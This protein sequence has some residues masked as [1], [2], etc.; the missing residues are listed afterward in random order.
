MTRRR[1]PLL[2][3]ALALP[4]AGW[5]ALALGA[6]TPLKGLIEQRAGD[7]LGRKVIIGGPVR[8]WLTPSSVQLIARDVHVAN[9]GWASTPALLRAD[10]VEARLEI[11]DLLIGR[12]G[13][14]A[15]ALRDGALELERSA[16]GARVN[17]TPGRTG[18]LFDPA[19][20][21][22]LS[23]ERM[24]LRYRD[25]AAK[26]DA[27][28]ELDE[29]GQGVIRLAG[30]A[31]LDGQ[32]VG[33]EGTL[34]SAPSEPTRLDIGARL[35]GVSLRLARLA[36]RGFPAGRRARTSRNWPR[37]AGSSCRRCPI[38]RSARASAM[39]GKAGTSAISR[40]ASGGPTSPAG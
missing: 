20:V 36:R 35:S 9:A 11:F 18:A 30:A 14:R 5:A 19:A 12:P 26:A 34:R 15:L 37:W 28:L 6:A 32:R 31:M 10:R 4:V 7:A 8:I 1:R 38:S 21:R 22:Q 33:I 3:A 25:P 27:R 23:A 2:W 13:L 17:W 24:T 16:D 39:C 40:G 29:G